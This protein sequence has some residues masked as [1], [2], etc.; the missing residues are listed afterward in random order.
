MLVAENAAV[1][2]DHSQ[3]EE[4]VRTYLVGICLTELLTHLFELFFETPISS[5]L[6][7]IIYRCRTTFTLTGFS[8][9]PGVSL[10]LSVIPAA[11][12]R[13]FVGLRDGNRSGGSQCLIITDLIPETSRNLRMVVLRRLR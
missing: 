6:M 12:R 11:R 5:R 10:R 2:H 13:G 8:V 1:A 4:G 9:I 3:A 7:L